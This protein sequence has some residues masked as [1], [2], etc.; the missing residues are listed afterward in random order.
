MSASATFLAVER[1]LWDD[2][3]R[4][5]ID[6]YRQGLADAGWE[7]PHE[8]PRFGLAASSALR[9]WPGVVRLLLPT[10]L[11]EA[12]HRRAKAVLGSPFH[13]IVD[14]SA[15]LDGLASPTRERRLTTA[16]R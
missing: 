11:D 4:T 9:H 12:A 13:E 14:L 3:E 7:G 6:A 16:P 15:R 8:Q 1:P 2:L 10:L 5:A